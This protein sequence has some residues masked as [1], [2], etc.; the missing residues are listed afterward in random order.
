[1]RQEAITVIQ[2]RNNED[3]RWAVGVGMKGRDIL[4]ERKLKVA[5]GSQLGC[6]S[7]HLWIIIAIDSKV[8]PQ[9]TSVEISYN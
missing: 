7:D 4:N 1:M 5:G 3:L 2:V 6:V 9:A 8:V